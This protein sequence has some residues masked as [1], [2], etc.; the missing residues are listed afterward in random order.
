MTEQIRRSATGATSTAAGGAAAPVR[1][2]PQFRQNRAPGWD[3]VVPHAGQL[4][5]SA[6][7]QLSQNFA[8]AGFCPRQLPHSA[9]GGGYRRPAPP[10]AVFAI[11]LVVGGRQLRGVPVGTFPAETPA[12]SIG[13]SPAQSRCGRDRTR[14]ARDCS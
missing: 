2:C 1:A 4:V 9:I 7:P 5:T 8:L 13:T 6:A 14:S 12:S 3:G 10:I 11:R